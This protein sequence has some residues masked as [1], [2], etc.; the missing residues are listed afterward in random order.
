MAGLKHPVT[1][2]GRYFVIRGK[3]SRLA[4]PE[5]DPERKTALVHDLM[6]ARRAAKDAKFSG[7]R[8]AEAEAHRSVDTAKQALGGAGA[9]LVEGRRARPKQADGEEH[10]VRSKSPWQAGVGAGLGQRASGHRT[11][12]PVDRMRM[13]PDHPFLVGSPYAGQTLL[14]SVGRAMQCSTACR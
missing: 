5:I 6:A 10:P 14:N 8:K 2:D 7:D 11:Y 9:G 3:L 1:P 4:N 12:G 13:E